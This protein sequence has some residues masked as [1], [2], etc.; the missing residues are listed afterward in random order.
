MARDAIGAPGVEAVILSPMTALT[1][2]KTAL[3]QV[4][5]DA[6]VVGLSSGRSGPAL[7]PGAADVDKA[8][9]KQ[10]VESL[11]AVGATGRA[12]EVTR[13]ATLGRVTAPVLVAVGLGAT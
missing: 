3:S 1:L 13:I 5:A 2:T 10:L 7:V 11:K 8:F 12:G 9:K 6:I 4:K